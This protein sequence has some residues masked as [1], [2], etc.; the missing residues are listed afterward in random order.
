MLK[1]LNTTELSAINGG[2]A[3]RVVPKFQGGDLMGWVLVPADSGIVEYRFDSR[4]W[5]YEPL[6][7]HYTDK[8]WGG[9]ID[10]M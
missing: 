5:R 6:Y 3:V 10:W 8:V 2:E 7:E 9:R 4:S 1:T